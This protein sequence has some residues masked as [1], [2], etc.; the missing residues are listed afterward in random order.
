MRRSVRARCVRVLSDDTIHSSCEKANVC[1]TT[2]SSAAAWSA[3][4]AV[5]TLQDSVGTQVSSVRP[6]ACRVGFGTADRFGV[7][8][9]NGTPGPGAYSV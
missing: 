2:R 8:K 5:Y 9:S 1:C 7:V 3:V 4:S 6:S